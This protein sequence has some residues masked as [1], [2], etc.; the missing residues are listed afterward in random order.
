[1]RIPKHQSR[2]RF[3]GVISAALSA[4]FL[5]LPRYADAQ[6]NRRITPLS[7]PPVVNTDLLEKDTRLGARITISAKG[8]AFSDVCTL[9]TRS[10]GIIFRAKR[11]VADDKVTLFCTAR[12]VREVMA[13]IARHFQF[14]WARQATPSGSEYLLY[15]TAISA[16]REKKSLEQERTEALGDLSRK[17]AAIGKLVT[18]S[19]EELQERAETATEP[20][21]SLLKALAGVGRTPA[22]LLQ[23]L[24]S[25]EAVALA[26]G[27][28]LEFSSVPTTGQSVLPETLRQSTLLVAAGK[29]HTYVEQKQ[30]GSIALNHGTDDV[31]RPGVPLSSFPG[32]VAI[33]Q[34]SLQVSKDTGQMEMVGSSGYR[35][36]GPNGSFISSFG[37]RLATGYSATDKAVG[38]AENNKDRKTFPEFQKNV[39][40]QPKPDCPQTHIASHKSSLNGV[41]HRV[42]SGDVLEAFHEATGQDVIGDYFSV[43]YQPAFVSR[44]GSTLFDTLNSICD[45]LHVR[46]DM[47]GN[48]LTFRHIQYCRLRP[49][50]VSNRLLSQ[51]VKARNDAG[52]ALPPAKLA[53]LAQCSDEQLDASAVAETIQDCYGIPEWNVV[54]RKAIRPHWRFFATLTANQCRAALNKNGL[55]VASMSAMQQ[56]Q[57]RS[58]FWDGL[59]DIEATIPKDVT[60]SVYAFTVSTAPNKTPPNK[61]SSE[62]DPAYVF[63]YRWGGAQDMVCKEVGMGG[64]IRVY[65]LRPNIGANTKLQAP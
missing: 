43:L 12:P 59:L 8:M 7:S 58:L 20:E 2:H 23:Q 11:T 61:A 35:V 21:K 54:R 19:P 17:M 27:K 57:L 65:R 46:W 42:T 63:L 49:R 45:R 29:K 32:A 13:L 24:T 48:F 30:D 14:E 16:R 39:S 37:T 3:F 33:A 6:T 62:A 55:L 40:V 44:E 1:M 5:L 38:N 25:E 28:T 9:L 51:W 10:T 22:Q 64:S 18:L 50:E 36:T 31:T 34:L 60:A 4:L 53:E 26:A 56:E 41:P 52:G 15:Q 47:Q